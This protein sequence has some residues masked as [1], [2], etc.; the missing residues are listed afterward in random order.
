M[1]MEEIQKMYG[2]DGLTMYVGAVGKQVLFVYGSDGPTLESAVAAAQ[3]N[4]DTFS[5]NPAVMATKDQRAGGQSD[6]GLL[7][8]D[9]ATRVTLA[10]SIISFHS[11]A[12]DAPASPAVSNAPPLVSSLGVT[13]SMLTSELHV[14][15]SPRSAACR[16][17]SSGCNVK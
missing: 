11:P 15:R 16:K 6:R 17:P 5:S 3:A 12:A 1:A 14:P 13:G 4:T 7:S 9:H 2:P 10:Q 8:A